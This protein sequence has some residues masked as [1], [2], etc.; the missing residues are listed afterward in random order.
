MSCIT[1][2]CDQRRKFRLVSVPL[3]FVIPRLDRGIQKSKAYAGPRDQ[4]AGRQLKEKA[5]FVFTG[6]AIHVVIR[7]DEFDMAK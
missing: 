5:V 4:V 1:R 6:M 3:L 2:L 7:V